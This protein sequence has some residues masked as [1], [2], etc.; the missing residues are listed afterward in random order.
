MAWLTQCGPASDPCR[1]VEAIPRISS[2][3]VGRF[4][5]ESQHFTYLANVTI[6]ARKGAVNVTSIFNPIAISQDV[7][8]RLSDA[9][10]RL[11]Q[12]IINGF[13]R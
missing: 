13:A 4:G 5:F 2:R 3:G 6:K 1:V 12:R 9:S 10:P 7:D 8:T 11:G